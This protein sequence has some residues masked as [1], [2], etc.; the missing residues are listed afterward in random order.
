MSLGPIESKVI[1]LTHTGMIC[2][3]GMLRAGLV[4]SRAEF[5]L[6]DFD[7]KVP[8]L[9]TAAFWDVVNASSAP[10]DAELSDVLDALNSPEAVTVAELIAKATRDTAEWLMSRKNRRAI[11]HR[12]ERCGYVCV[13]NPDATDGLWK[14]Q[15]ARQV[16][17]AQASLSGR[18]RF[19]AA[20]RLL[21]KAGSAADQ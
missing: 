15:G 21:T 5:D 8:P 19:A 7:P 12:L 2:G 1:F 3:A 13:R 10:E 18:E 9:K 14:V 6:S 17:Y 11:P 4:T 16:I 20:Q